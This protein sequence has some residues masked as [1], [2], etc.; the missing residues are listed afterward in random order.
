MATLLLSTVGVAASL[1]HAPVGRA[2]AQTPQNFIRA[3]GAPGQDCQG[4]PIAYGWVYNTY[5]IPAIRVQLLIESLDA[6]GETISQ[7]T[8]RVFG[9][10][11][12]NNRVAWEARVLE[13]GTTYRVTVLY[14]DWLRAGGAAN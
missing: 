7:T 9:D 14:A 3:E 13:A 12:G 1:P 5:W 4:R 10:V 8:T 2:W 11:P 6:S